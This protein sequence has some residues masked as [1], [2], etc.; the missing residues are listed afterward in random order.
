METR[1]KELE[2]RLQ[3]VQDTMFRIVLLNVRLE[4]GEA[5][6]DDLIRGVESIW[7]TYVEVFGEPVFEEEEDEE[8]ENFVL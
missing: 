2:K 1:I 8:G 5:D 3:I 6:T 7:D 4:N